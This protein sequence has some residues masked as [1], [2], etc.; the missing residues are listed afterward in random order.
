MRP[1]GS[2]AALEERRRLAVARVLEGY[3]AEEVADF[4]G[5]E[6]RSV[7]RWL[8]AFRQTGEEGL[9]A[10]PVPGRPPKLDSR[11][12]DRVLSWIQGDSQ[13]FGFSTPRWT[14]PRLAIVIARELGVQLHPRYLNAWLRA[15]GV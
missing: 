13:K 4:L 9:Q 10:A 6:P 11:Q 5:V 12:A 2:C 8:A 14:A 15:H 3:T 7:Y 1:H